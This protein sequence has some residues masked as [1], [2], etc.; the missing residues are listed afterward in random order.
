MRTSELLHYAFR[1]RDPLALGKWYADLFDGQFFVHPVM[2]ALGIVIVKI[3]HPEAV[4]DGLIEFWPWDLQW[5]G[6]AAVFRKI[7]SEPSPTSYGHMAVKVVAETDAI[8][9]ELDRR[10]I[11]Y[12]LEPRAM[13]FLLP[14]IADPEGNMIELFPNIDNVPLP[15]KAMCPP[16]QIDAALAQVHAGFAEL[17]KNLKPGDGVPLLLFEMQ[18]QQQQQ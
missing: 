18:Q 4:F 15:G 8:R 17:T 6:A 2:S 10:G 13:G 5:D 12:R 1:A 14:V 7:K 11:A 3:N 9:A 16:E